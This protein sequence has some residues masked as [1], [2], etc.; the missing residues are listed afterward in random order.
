MHSLEVSNISDLLCKAEP[1]EATPDAC[2]REALTLAAYARRLTDVVGS[3][4]LEAG[5]LQG[6]AFALEGEAPIEA[7]G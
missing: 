5:R 1:T 7:E 2:R 6:L 4:Q 3:I